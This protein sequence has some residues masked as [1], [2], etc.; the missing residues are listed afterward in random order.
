MIVDP[1]LFEKKT[2]ISQHPYKQNEPGNQQIFGE[3]QKSNGQSK[4]QERG[5]DIKE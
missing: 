1:S 5:T 3:K 4:P 2:Y